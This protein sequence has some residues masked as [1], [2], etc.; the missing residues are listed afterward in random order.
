MNAEL[1][2]V[3]REIRSLENTVMSTDDL[4]HDTRCTRMDGLKR[5]AIR[6]FEA[7]EEVRSIVEIGTSIDRSIA[8]PGSS[9]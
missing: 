7:I 4:D 8:L 9:D 3:M 5:R 1:K 6:L 2:A